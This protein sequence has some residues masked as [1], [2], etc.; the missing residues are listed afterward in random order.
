MIYWAWNN[1]LSVIQQYVIMRR[2]G[3][4]VELWDNLRTTFAKRRQR[5]EGS[6]RDRADV[7]RWPRRSDDDDAADL[8]EA[9]RLLFAGAADFYAAAQTLDTPAAHGGRRD[10][11]RRAARTSASR[12]SS[13]R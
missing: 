5:H 8:A 12:A 13:T 6:C 4:K 9:G 7:A 10:R 2:N 1:S 3:V 11:L